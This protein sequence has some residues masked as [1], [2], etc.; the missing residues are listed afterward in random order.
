MP[1]RLRSLGLGVCAMLIASVLACTRASVLPDPAV[2]TGTA[3]SASASAPPSRPIVL[4]AP[5]ASVAPVT[6]GGATLSPPPTAR[7][8][9]AWTDPGAVE[10]LTA[11]CRAPTP[12]REDRHGDRDA[13]ACALPWQQSCSYDPCF[14]KLQECR[15][16]CAKTCDSC[17]AS[18]ATTCDDCKAGCKD[19]ACRVGCATKTGECKQACLSTTDR[20][21]TGRCESESSAC[22]AEQKRVWK[23]HGCSCKKISPCT[24]RCMNV[25]SEC[26][27][28][29]C[30]DA[31]PKCTARCAARFPGCD[32]GYCIMGSEPGSY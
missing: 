24:E 22:Y 19:A 18:C 10:A 1:V 7:T 2:T 23:S 9:T 15:G 12:A 28:D 30:G 8:F 3:P 27:G 25:M 11:S 13:L 4:A 31:F 21:A 29:D 16:G 17:D 14:Q 20:C 5:S 26:K 6:S 32:V